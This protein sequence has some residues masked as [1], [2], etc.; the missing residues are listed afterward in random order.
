M[1]LNALN[2]KEKESF[3]KLAHYS[4]EIDGVIKDEEK[5]ILKNFIF[6]CQLID[7]DIS[8]DENI[9]V[10]ADTLTVSSTK[11]K[12][13]IILELLGVLLADGDYHETEQ[14]FI[15]NLA[16]KFNVKDFEVNRMERWVEAFN[17]MVRE[18]YSLVIK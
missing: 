8:Y 10:I 18:G 1:Y 2:N 9:D 17:D 11:V 14:G 7:Y 15:K 16:E 6:E 4:M 5:A 13:I 12:K 3:L